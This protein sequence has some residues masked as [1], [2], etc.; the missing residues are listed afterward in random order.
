MAAQRAIKPWWQRLL[1]E[2]QTMACFKMALAQVKNDRD[3]GSS[4]SPRPCEIGLE[5]IVSKRCR[6]PLQERP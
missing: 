3:E 4:S 1:P 2:G 6:Q 5:G